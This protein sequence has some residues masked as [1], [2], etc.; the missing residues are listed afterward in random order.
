[1]RAPWLGFL[2]PTVAL[3]CVVACWAADDYPVFVYPCPRAGAAIVLEGVPNEPAWAEAPLVTGF[4][5]YDR[6]ERV[7][8]Q[9]FFRALYD[10]RFLY[11]GVTCEEPAMDRLAVTPSWRD[12]TAI[13][14]T[15]AVEVFVDPAHGHA[16][17]FQFA[18]D[19]AGDVYDARLTD[20]MWNAAALAATSRGESAW[21]LE[22]AIPWADLGI[23][24]ARPGQVV[25]FN[26]C[27]DRYLG[28]AR[29]WTN[30]SQTKAN[31]HDPE[32]F[33]HLVL[34]PTPQTLA[35]LTDDFRKGERRGPLYV[36]SGE[37][38]AGVTY[39]AMAERLLQTF[40]DCAA[41]FKTIRDEQT[42]PQL[43]AALDE[44]LP[45]IA[46]KV[47]P[48]RE[49]LASASV[50]DAGLWAEVDREVTAALAELSDAIWEARIQALL[51]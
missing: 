19:A 17:Y 38:F 49:A 16:R 24:A 25:G 5:Y 4:T 32:R 44:Q 50:V 20:P 11:F 37:G 30:W 7:P 34:S 51:E 42:S 46:G 29:E 3:L 26:L 31:F 9:T 1:M 22:A 43:A 15:E 18:F 8:V 45:A 10:D 48:L 14:A 40:D 28:A 2:V 39:R 36:F 12:A 41:V 27:R 47:T 35:A 33:A 13:F 6:S 23:E 21:F